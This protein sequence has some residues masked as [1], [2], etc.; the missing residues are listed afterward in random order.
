MLPDDAG[1]GL[2]PASEA[3][4][5]SEWM[6]PGCDQMMR[7]WAA[8]EGA[9]P[10]HGAQGGAHL[11]GEGIE[12]F[13]VLFRVLPEPGDGGGEAFG[14]APGNSL[15]VRVGFACAPGTDVADLFLG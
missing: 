11:L 10:N 6:R 5:A 9:N 7:N 4:A 12:G 8:R 1:I 13:Q 3:K 2:A 15:G 14:F